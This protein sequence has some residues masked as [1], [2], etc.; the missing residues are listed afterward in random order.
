MKLFLFDFDGVL[1]ESLEIYEK[2]VCLCLQKINK[3]LT[4][5]RDE[6]LELFEGNFYESLAKRGV[7][8]KEFMEVSAG[9]LTQVDYKEMRPVTAM[10]AVVDQL[11][12]NNILLVISSNNS[13]TISLAL[14]QFK[15]NGYFQEVLGSD[16][17]LSKKEKMLYATRKYQIVP[18]DIYYI[19]DTTGDIAEGRDAGVK[20]VGVTWGWHSKEKMAQAQPDYLVNEPQELLQLN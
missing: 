13:E 10:I 9:L 6:F 7:D 12:R 20:T 4:R 17:L 11:Q 16:F 19:G 2:I 8:L 3:P 18:E 14:E 1:V 15:F 5:G